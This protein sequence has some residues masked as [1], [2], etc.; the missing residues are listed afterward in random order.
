MPTPLAVLFDFDGV[1]ADTENVHVAA[2]Q[3]TLA[4]IGWELADEAAARAAEIDDRYFLQ[5]LFGRRNIEGADLDGWIRRKPR[6]R[7][8]PLRR[9]PAALSGGG[10]AGPGAP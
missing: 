8:D 5:E 2:W 10:G 1:L 7:G 6:P 4:R 3:R 9:R